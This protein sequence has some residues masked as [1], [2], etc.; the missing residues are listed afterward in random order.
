MR[1]LY[2]LILI[3]FICPCC[4]ECKTD[5]KAVYDSLNNDFTEYSRT[6]SDEVYDRIIS[7]CD[8]IIESS[9]E[10]RNA[11]LRSKSNILAYSNQYDEAVK[12]VEQIPDTASIFNSFISKTVHINGL[13]S[14]KSEMLGDE[15]S[16]RM[17]NDKILSELEGW[18]SVRKDSLYHALMYQP[19]EVPVIRNQHIAAFLFYLMQLSIYDEQEVKRVIE[20]LK[21]EIPECNENTIDYFD[22][23]GSCF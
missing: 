1:H 2:L 15:D 22:Y 6:Y 13:L 23:F 9:P 10:F 3:V 7:K 8:L 16:A 18:I 20:N 5:W 17:Y 21:R 11:A 14:S 19:M 4:M 12:V